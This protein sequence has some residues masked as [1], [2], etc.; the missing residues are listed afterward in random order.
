MKDISAL[1]SIRLVLHRAYEGRSDP[2]SIR[3]VLHQTQSRN[4]HWNHKNRP[5]GPEPSH[6][7]L[8][9]LAFDFDDSLQVVLD[10]LWGEGYFGAVGGADDD[11]RCDWGG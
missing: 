3:F 9:P 6:A 10:T 8:F 11:V 2:I 7:L 4:Y 5:S 1:I